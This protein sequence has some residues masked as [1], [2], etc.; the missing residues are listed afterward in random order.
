[1]LYIFLLLAALAH[2]ANTLVRGCI[3]YLYTFHII[4]YYL[5]AFVLFLCKQHLYLSCERL[6]MAG[7]DDCNILQPGHLVRSKLGVTHDSINIQKLSPYGFACTSSQAISRVTKEQLAWHNLRQT[8]VFGG[9]Q[10]HAT[11]MDQDL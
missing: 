4:K 11:W 8:R 5:C 6:H 3:M 2:E 9:T 10:Y 7:L 1:L